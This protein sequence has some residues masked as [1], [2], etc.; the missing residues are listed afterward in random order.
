MNNIFLTGNPGSGKSTI[1]KKLIEQMDCSIGGFIENKIF[2]YNKTVFEI[3]SLSDG[4][5]GVIGET[6]GL[7]NTRIN[8]SIFETLGIKILSDS[9]KDSDVIIIDE[10]GF[11]ESSCKKFIMSVNK[12]LD[13][14][15]PV[16]GVLKK[17]D[18][19][20]LNSIKNR[21]DTYI[22][23]VT[24]E[25]RDDALYETLKAVKSIGIPVKKLNIK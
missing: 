13:S 24:E 14:K 20:F 16:I 2:E 19:D 12:A 21:N 25:N 5:R 3:A 6:S 8:P 11:F 23:E 4:L 22:I 17:Y 1:I 18:S 7:K 15:K 10:L 9:L